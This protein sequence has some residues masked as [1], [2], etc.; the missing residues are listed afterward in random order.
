MIEYRRLEFH[1]RWF[2]KFEEALHEERGPLWLKDPR[3]AKVVSDSLHHLDGESYTLHA[4]C[5][6]ANHVHTLFT[7]FLD[8]LSLTEVNDPLLRFESDNPTLGAIMQSL[9]G[10]TAREANKLLDRRGKFWDPES[11]D[12]EVRNGNEFC[13]IRS[14]ILN[15]PVKAG[16][17]RESA[18]WRWSWVETDATG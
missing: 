15:N 12:H 17:V 2:G 11:Y 13:R 1:R 7:P 10:Y 14:Y 3:V 6:M 5:V 9:K 18:D 4:Y 16:L 8:E